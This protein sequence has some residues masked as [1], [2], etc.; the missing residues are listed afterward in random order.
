MAPKVKSPTYKRRYRSFHD[1]SK[2]VHSLRLGSREDW[3]RYVKSG[4]KPDDIPAAPEIVYKHDGWKGV[5][6]WLGT[7]RKVLPTIVNIGHF[8]KQD[9]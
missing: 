6:D 1:A 2:Y 9:N 8:Q 7:G 3:K 4:N 5:G